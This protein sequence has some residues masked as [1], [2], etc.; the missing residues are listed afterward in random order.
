[1]APQRIAVIGAGVSGLTAAYVLDRGGREVTVFEADARIG[2]HAHTHDVTASD[3]RGFAVDSGFI[4]FNSRT[5]PTLLKLFAELGVTTQPTEMS[6]SVK[7]LECK[8]E[9]GLRPTGGG[10]LGRL[11]P[12]RRLLFNRKYLRLLK[13]G[14]I[15]IR[16]AREL[17][18]Q[19]GELR[20]GDYHYVP[21]LTTGPTLGEFLTAKDY[22]DYFVQHLIVP[23]VSAVWSCSPEQAAEYPAAYLFAYL[24]N[25]GLLNLRDQPTW[26]TVSG[27]SRTYVEKL[28]AQLPQLRA[29]TPV[30]SVRRTADGVEIRTAN[31]TEAYDAVVMATHADHALKLLAD[32]TED[33]RSLLGAFDYSR[34]EIILHTDAGMLPKESVRC[35]WNSLLPACRPE[36][37]SVRVSYQMNRLMRLD[38]P[39]EFVVTLNGDD[40]IDP[41]AVRARMTYEH[42]IYTAAALTAQRRLPELAT[43][44]TTY[45]GSYHGWGFHEDG[46]RSAVEAAAA[47]GVQW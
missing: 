46:C 37:G 18:E 6:S 33:E 13:Q 47:L 5:Y 29:A 36:P 44:R 42:P 4:V 25:H 22:P 7:C 40:M 26:M 2:G 43:D 15:F 17:L 14:P 16:D 28:T 21:D 1:M 9:Y 38:S 35:S 30:Q 11:F 20:P 31:G 34:N 19:T 24:H 45:A 10:V 39:D 27:G 23:W 3:G 8:L 12:D 32:P 41:S